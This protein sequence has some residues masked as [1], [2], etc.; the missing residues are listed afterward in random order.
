M[1]LY[2]LIDKIRVQIFVCSHYIEVHKYIICNAVHMYTLLYIIILLCNSTMKFLFPYNWNLLPINHPFC[3]SLCLLSHASGYHH[4]FLT[5]SDRHFKIPH[6]TDNMKHCQSLLSLF[7][8][9]IMISNFMQLVMNMRIEILWLNSILL[10][11][12]TVFIC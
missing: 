1:Y 11:M 8:F 4:F 6:I 9:K 5:S 7:T 3:F 12:C 10:Y 2:I